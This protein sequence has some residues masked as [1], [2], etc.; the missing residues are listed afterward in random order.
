[1]VLEWEDAGGG[2]EDDI[3]DGDEDDEMQGVEAGRKPFKS[4]K[5][6][7]RAEMD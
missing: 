3:S 7:H 2:G 6:A 5:R 4:A 1:M